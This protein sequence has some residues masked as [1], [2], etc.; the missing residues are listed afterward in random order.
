VNTQTKTD[1]RLDLTIQATNGAT[2]PTDEFKPNTKVKHVIDKA[3]EHFI[4]EAWLE[5]T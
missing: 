5:P 3:V 1:K 4:A 2:W